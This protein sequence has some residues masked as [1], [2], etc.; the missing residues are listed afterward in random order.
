MYGMCDGISQICFTKPY[1][2]VLYCMY[3]S[4]R[5]MCGKLNDLLLRLNCVRHNPY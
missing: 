4:V 1:H 2:Y 3:V 5:L